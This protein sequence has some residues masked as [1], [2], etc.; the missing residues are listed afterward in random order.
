MQNVLK[1]KNMHLEGF[2]VRYL[3]FFSSKSYFL[4]HFESFNMRYA[5]RKIIF[6]KIVFVRKN[7]YLL[8]GG[9]GRKLRTFPLLLGFLMTSYVF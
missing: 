4:D 7:R 3:N 1:R 5:C 9:G 8:Y 6:K 2:Q